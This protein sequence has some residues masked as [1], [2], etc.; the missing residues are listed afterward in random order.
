VVLA[1]AVQSG[2]LFLWDINTVDLP[3]QVEGVWKEEHSYGSCA[4]RTR[5]WLHCK[6]QTRLLIREGV[7]HQEPSKCPI[8]KK[9]IK[10]W[11]WAP[12]IFLTPKQTGQLTDSHNNNDDDNSTIT[13]WIRPPESL[14]TS[15]GQNIPFVN[16]VKY[17][18]VIFN[19]KITCKLHIETVATKVFSTFIRL[20]SLCKS[21]WLSTKIKL[22]AH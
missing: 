9:K 18:S 2:T 4:I 19:K 5:E 6:L 22:T 11:S 20:H 21:E 8:E 13:H 3:L 12:E 1:T 10:I 7:P 14:L 16:N 17:F 15:Y